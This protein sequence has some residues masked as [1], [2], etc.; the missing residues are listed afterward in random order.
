MAKHLIGNR[1][2]VFVTDAAPTLLVN[3][4]VTYDDFSGRGLRACTDR[5]VNGVG[6]RLAARQARVPQIDDERSPQDRALDQ[7][8][9]F[10]DDG[11][12]GIEQTQ[13]DG[14]VPVGT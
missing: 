13:T 2:C 3:Q 11:P 10:L 7:R 4:V 12:V 8:F 14:E 9:F 6:T 5:V 1:I